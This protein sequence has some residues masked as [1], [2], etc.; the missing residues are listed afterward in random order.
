MHLSLLKLNCGICLWRSLHSETENQD[1][2]GKDKEDKNMWKKSLQAGERNEEQ[3]L[4]V[5]EAKRDGMC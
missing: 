1:L 4:K 2:R 3:R 5:L